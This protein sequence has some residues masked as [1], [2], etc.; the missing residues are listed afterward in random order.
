[1]SRKALII[2][3]F[4]MSAFGCRRQPN[5]TNYRVDSIDSSNFSIQFRELQAHE[6]IALKL[7]DE[8]ILK[9][10]AKAGRKP[11]FWRYYY[12]PKSI[13]KIEFSN[14]LNGQLKLRKIFKD[15]LVNVAHRTLIVSRPFP[16]GLNAKNWKPYGF[17]SI[18]TGTRE[19]RLVND[20]VAFREY[21]TDEVIK[22]Q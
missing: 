14:Y 17:V 15:T 5:I 9:D 20:A 21:W 10:S 19:V 7:N 13:V 6:K 4:L 1:M 2:V 16:K 3:L 8:L 22:I 11:G 12:Y 18:D